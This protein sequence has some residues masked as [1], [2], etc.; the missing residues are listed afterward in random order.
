MGDAIPQ[1]LVNGLSLGAAYALIALGFVLVINA[2]GAVNFAQGDL[3]MAGGFVAVILAETLTS[4]LGGGEALIGLVVLPLTMAVMAVIGL[5]FSALAYA[6]LRKRPPVSVFISTIAVGIILQHAANAGFGPE[7]RLGPALL[8]SDTFRLGPVVFSVQ[9]IAVILAAGALT[10]ATGLLLTRTQLGR[11][12]RA[13]AQDSEIAEAVGI[14]GG[15]CIA[16]TFALAVALAGAVGML[17]S[18]QFFVAPGDGGLFMLKAYIAVTLGGWGRLDGAALAALLIGVFEVLMAAFVSYVV[19]EALLYGGLL[20][21]LL[22]R[23]SGLF[24]ETI[25]RRT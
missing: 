15:R 17:L 12:L 25:Q 2:V 14:N 10:G 22:V 24:G 11:K 4:W 6:P 18:N 21:V 16:I 9:Q 20:L 23:P 1:L 7:P 8:G 3:V 5:I 13:V 19:A